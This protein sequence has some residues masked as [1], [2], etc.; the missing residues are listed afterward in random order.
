MACPLLY[1]EDGFE[2]QFGTNHMGH[3]ALTIGLIPALQA[4][5]KALG[6]GSRVVNV[7]SLAHG[8]QDID[9]NDINYKTREYEPW[10]AYAQS[11]TANILFTVEFNKRYSKDGIFAN[12]LTP[13]AVATNLQRNMSQ[14]EKIKMNVVDENG[15]MSSKFRPVDVGANTSVWAAVAKELENRGGLYLEN[16]SISS[17]T[18][19][20]EAYKTFTGYL[21]HAMN[22]ESSKK[23][24]KISEKWVENPP[25]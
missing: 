11:K 24:W 9:F 6:K 8:R 23:L 2:M 13:G 7:S 25:K 19:I 22:L 14:E 17:E 16:C 10:L 3:F 21:P 20:E 1:T 12:S 15:K 18:T 5:Y 4:G